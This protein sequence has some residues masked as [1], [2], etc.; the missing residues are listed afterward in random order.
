[1]FQVILYTVENNSLK[2]Y[3]TVMFNTYL[4]ASEFVDRYAALYLDEFEDSD[5]FAETGEYPDFEMFY[6]IIVC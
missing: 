1:M 6:E 3:R 4:A 5:E 2:T